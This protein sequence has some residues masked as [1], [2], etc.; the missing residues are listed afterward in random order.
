MP[1]GFQLSQRSR[2]DQGAP[3]TRAAV[4]ARDDRLSRREGFLYLPTAIPTYHF[5]RVNIYPQETEGCALITHPGV[6]D[7]GSAFP[8]EMAKRQGGGQPHDIR[9]PAGRWQPKA[10]I[11]FFRQASCR[12][13]KCPRKHRLSGF[14]TAAHPDRPLKLHF[15]F[16]R[17]VTGRRRA[18]RVRFAH[19]PLGG[20]ST[21]MR[22]ERRVVTVS[23]FRTVP[24]LRD[25]PPPSHISLSPVI[26]RA[27]ARPVG[28]M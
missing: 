1:P 10:D 15:F 18:V 12:R 27:F 2:E 19:L 21:R 23:S 5:R 7:R 24:E 6:A 14:R 28:S 22:N 8:Q 11:W 3:T 17:Q 13:S 25:H 9:A 26:G 4:D 16:A 20:G